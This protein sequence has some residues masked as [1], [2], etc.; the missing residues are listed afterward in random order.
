MAFQWP[1]M[2]AAV[3]VGDLGVFLTDNWFH[4]LKHHM[5]D[6]YVSLNDLRC[7]TVYTYSIHENQ[8]H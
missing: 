3:Y 5:S 8:C 4:E 7:I 1:F 2:T 6:I